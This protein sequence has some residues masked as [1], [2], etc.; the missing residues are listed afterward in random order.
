[1]KHGNDNP[2]RRRGGFTL[3]EMLVVVLV[4]ALIVGMALPAMQGFTRGQRLKQA[5]RITERAIR[6]ARSL[7]IEN[8]AVYTVDFAGF[9]QAVYI[10]WVAWPDKPYPYPYNLDPASPWHKFYPGDYAGGF[11]D[12]DHAY[13]DGRDNDRDNTV[14]VDMSGGGFGV[15]DLAETRGNGVDDD[16][17]K[18]VDEPAERVVWNDSGDGV[19]RPTSSSGAAGE[20]MD[21]SQRDRDMQKLYS[22]CDMGVTQPMQIPGLCFFNTA[23]ADW[24]CD[25]NWGVADGE[26]DD[27]DLDGDNNE[28]GANK[29]GW[30]TKAADVATYNEYPD[31]AF[32]PDGMVLDPDPTTPL[33]IIISDPGTTD[34]ARILVTGSGRTQSYQWDTVGAAWKELR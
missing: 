19:F 14:D 16:Y 12:I 2:G 18:M 23:D 13:R 5:C 28:G 21:M 9:G 20:S 6:A 15:L 31:I 34:K 22:A 29:A 3:A 24:N 8:G 32:G 1:M 25:D 10:Q 26:R 30:N 17:N 11:T 27:D 4:I 7:A 33:V